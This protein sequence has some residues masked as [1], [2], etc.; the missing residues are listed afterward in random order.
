MNFFLPPCRYF[1]STSAKI[2]HHYSL[3]LSLTLSVTTPSC[4]HSIVFLLPVLTL[5]ISHVVSMFHLI[6]FL[7]VLATWILTFIFESV[8]SKLSW[9]FV[10]WWGYNYIFKSEGIQFSVRVLAV[11]PMQNRDVNKHCNVTSVC[12]LHSY[13]WLGIRIYPSLPYMHINHILFNHTQKLVQ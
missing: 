2:N 7:T 9:C 6:S 10:N 8:G 13:D 3:L 4:I 12:N 1:F 11:Y 5:C